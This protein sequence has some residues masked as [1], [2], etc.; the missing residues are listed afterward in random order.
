MNASH[1]RELSVSAVK[2]MNILSSRVLAE[3]EL[4]PTCRGIFGTL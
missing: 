3:L 2:I 4:T 1:G